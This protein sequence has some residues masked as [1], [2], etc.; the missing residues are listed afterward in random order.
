MVHKKVTNIQQPQE[1]MS[2]SVKNQ[3]YQKFKQLKN[4]KTKGNEYPERK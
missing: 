4:L 2:L 3:T 1:H